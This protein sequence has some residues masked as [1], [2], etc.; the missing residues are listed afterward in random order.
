MGK[1][2]KFFGEGGEPYMRGLSILEPLRN[3][4]LNPTYT[5]GT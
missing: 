3:Y 1:T 4:Q 2:F 5:R